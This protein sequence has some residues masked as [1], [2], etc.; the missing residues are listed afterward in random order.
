MPDN[1]I[2]QTKWHWC[3]QCGSLW[4]A[5]S[6]APSNGV[7]PA[8]KTGHSAAGS[9]DYALFDKPSTPFNATVMAQ[10]TWRWCHKCDCLW[11]AQSA[12]PGVCPAG[13]VHSAD[14]SGDYALLNDSSGSIG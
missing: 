7:C 1:I 14:G 13:G 6:A 11:H 12:A 3:D 4:H 8:T 5:K 2:A 9:G 10:S